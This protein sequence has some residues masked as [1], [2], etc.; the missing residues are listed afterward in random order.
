ML[1]RSVDDVSLHS[2]RTSAGFGL[3]RYLGFPVVP[4]LFALAV[5]R[6]GPWPIPT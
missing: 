5:L 1:T 6:F 2:G 4:G 3:L